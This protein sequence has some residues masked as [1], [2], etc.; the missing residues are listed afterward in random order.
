MNERS[1]RIKQLVE[2][3]GLS[4]LELEKKTGVKKSSLQRYASGATSKIPLDAIEKIAEAF[5]VDTRYILGWESATPEVKKN[6]EAIADLTSR[7]IV[8]PVFYDLVCDLSKLDESRL[9][10]ASAM[11]DLLF[12]QSVDQNKD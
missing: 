4:Y 1:L 11:L 9:R 3:S 7:M 5:E 8:D 10:D 2:E 12:K 6:S